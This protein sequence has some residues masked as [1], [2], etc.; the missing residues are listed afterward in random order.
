MRDTR[1]RVRGWLRAAACSA[2]AAGGVAGLATVP[3]AATVTPTAAQC[4]F[5]NSQYKHVIYVQ[6][7]NTH[8]R[9]DNPDVPSDLEQIPALRNF[10]ADNGSLMSN[11]HTILI[12]HTAG[13]IVSSLTGLYPDRN[14]INVAN[15]YQFFTGD[16]LST[17]F[18]SAFTYWTDPVGG[19]DNLPNL[20]TTGGANTPAPWT[21]FT[22][23]GC[24]VG[25]ASTADIELEN[26]STAPAGDITT[27]FGGGVSGLSSPQAAIALHDRSE[28]TTDLEGISIH[29]AIADSSPGG[30]CSSA[31]GGRPDTLPGQLA[32]PNALFGALYVNQVLAS[33]GHLT[34]ATTDATSPTFNGQT[35]PTAAPPVKDV[36]N[37][38]ASPGLSNP[39][40]QV[41]GDSSGHPGFPGFDPSAAQTLGY[42]AAMQE[43]GVPVTFAYI[44]DAH[45]D[46]TGVNNFNA[47]GP[48]QAGYVAQLSAENEAFTAFFDR[49]AQDGINQSNTLFVFTV[50]EGDHFAGG[51]PTNP[52]CD[53]VT[54]PC[55]YGTGTTGP[56]SVGEQD[57]D[58]VNALK[59]EKN[60][61]IPFDVHADSAPTF[62]VHGS[63]STSGPGATDPNVRQLERDVSGLTL[64]NARTGATDVVTQHIAD[65]TDEAI[66]HMVNA[67][68]S[69]TPSFTLFGNPDYYY[70]QE[71]SFGYTCPSGST[72]PGCPVVDNGFAWN[73]GDDNPVIG[74]T[75]FGMV[76]PNIR[77]L[78]Q[79]A[80]VWTDHTD[81][82]PTMLEALGLPSA[83]VPDGRVVTQVLSPSALPAGMRFQLPLIDDLGAVYKQLNAPFGQ[84]SHDSEIVS[85]R[86]VASS[87]P[88]DAVYQAWDA[89]LQ[90]CLSARDSIASQISA[91]LDADEFGGGGRS[92]GFGT[93]PLIISAERLVSEMHL[94]A[95]FDAPPR[96]P[97]CGLGPG[98]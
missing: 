39:P 78:G 8:L 1:F 91:A 66:L 35:V 36:F 97:I 89:Q 48:G 15:S 49:L 19:G 76:G 32:T 3:A 86:A 6:F 90:A 42:V 64:T 20:V 70:E 58:L 75:W 37:Y 77:H 71:G 55:T 92:D 44:A 45:D 95:R 50:D 59:L 38:A 52:G 11:D 25:A 79:T 2:L 83:Y 33:P 27:V 85:T 10:L 93:I 96:A 7:D 47:F 26:T 57:V 5:P 14:G 30:L 22:Q 28:A 98:R 60:D 23:A 94:L 17:G 87:S 80:A 9:R 13:G 46:H 63:S 53:G 43:A 29:C 4:A 62:Y 72:T 21:A 74:N 51:P 31:N 56:N 24:D 81:L 54:T 68:P 67:D 82:R 34:P 61:T 41:I 69:R 40:S 18:A 65:Q 73:H 84:F 16:P 88:G 12:S